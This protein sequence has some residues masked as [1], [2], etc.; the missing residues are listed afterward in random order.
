MMTGCK[1]QYKLSESDYI[2]NG[3]GEGIRDGIMERDSG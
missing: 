3:D 1:R 2:A